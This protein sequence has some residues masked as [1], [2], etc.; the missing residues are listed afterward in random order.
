MSSG[1]VFKATDMYP[2]SHRA[3]F[4][5][6]NASRHIATRMTCVGGL[7]KHVALAQNKEHLK[8]VKYKKNLSKAV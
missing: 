6:Y 3:I 5:R 1:S 4:V 8:R 7:R 2:V